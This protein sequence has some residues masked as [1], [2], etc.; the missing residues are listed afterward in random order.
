MTSSACKKDLD[1][2]IRRAKGWYKDHQIANESHGRWIIK[3]PSDVSSLT[4]S[5]ERKWSRAYW[6]EVAILSDGLLVIQGDTETVTLCPVRPAPVFGGAL[7]EFLSSCNRAVRELAQTARPDDEDFIEKGTLAATWTPCIRCFREELRELRRT[8]SDATKT[9][10]GRIFAQ[11]NDWG[12]DGDVAWFQERVCHVTGDGKGLIQ[13]RHLSSGMVSAH[14]I[15]QR[16][17]ALL[18]ERSLAPR[19]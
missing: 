3:K 14:A 7:L 19:F 8:S 12:S 11:V 1:A 2:H 4:E 15:L 13:G 16:L 9:G 5:H 18:D 10:L 6:A 17:G